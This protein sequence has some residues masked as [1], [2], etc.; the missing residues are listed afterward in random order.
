MTRYDQIAN[1]VESRFNES[2]EY[3]DEAWIVAQSYLSLL[4]GLAPPA[5]DFSA[6]D[7]GW[8]DI[9]VDVTG[10][11]APDRPTVAITIPS[12]PELPT[13]ETV[14]ISPVN[15]PTLDVVAP[16]YNDPDFPDDV[17]PD[18]PTDVP[19]LDAVTYP[20]PPDYDL[21]ETPVLGPD[22]VVPDPPD[23]VLPD[24][25]IDAPEFTVE[26]PGNSFVYTE[27]AYTS[28]LLDAAKAWLQDQIASGS[29]GLDADVEQAIID[30]AE[31]RQE[32]K[33]VD[34]YDEAEN[35]FAGRGH[36]LPLGALSGRLLRVLEQIGREEQQLSDDTMIEQAKL[37]QTNTHFV[38]ERSLSYEQ[39][40]QDHFNKVADR[41]F[42]VARAIQAAA[43][44]VFNGQ[45]AKYN[46][47][48][49]GYQ[50]TAQVYEIRI[51][52]ALLILEKYK[53]E[54][55]GV[56]LKGRLRE[57][58][59][60]LYNLQLE[61]TKTLVSLYATEM[62]SAQVKAQV[63]ATVIEAYR[64]RI[65]AYSAAIGAIT[66]KYNGYQAQLAGEQTKADVYK[67]Q[68]GA[69]Q[70]HISG[71]AAGAQV[72]IESARTTLQQNTLLIDQYRATID[73]FKAQIDA[74]K[75]VADSLIASYQ[76]RAAHESNL[77]RSSIAEAE[78][79]MDHAAKVYGVQVEQYKAGASI[80]AQVSAS[81]LS[82]VSA[83]ASYGYDE[84]VNTSY[85]YD[86]TKSDPT[87][88]YVFN[89]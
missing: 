75:A 59:L 81:A 57:Q 4:A 42:Q 63:N 48:L 21:P 25:D 88:Q 44:D 66:A 14:E 23:V 78:V 43:M 11:V 58:T 1:S 87:F 56:N 40:A 85:S 68:V 74:K 8:T 54:L 2:S 27:G 12:I 7:F 47:D 36:T 83:A 39:I 49:A 53:A 51:R 34:T 46:A 5:A 89:T 18:V 20:V 32:L 15:I 38:I 71:I 29:T 6:V 77:I 64:T 79:A 60:N 61:G 82:A 31:A 69:Y 19:S 22:L 33:H 80:T 50:A 41:A 3:A 52:A 13:L 26:S 37:A 45:V 76:A 84:G 55:E 73:R 9:S 28:E 86:Q 72:D 67:T 35:Y 10:P 17:M 16:A 24:L 62:Q 70:A 65:S 30:R